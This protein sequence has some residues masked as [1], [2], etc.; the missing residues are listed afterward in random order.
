MPNPPEPRPAGGYWMNETTGVLA[1][2]V[3][4]F[5]RHEPLSPSDIDLLRRSLAQWMGLPFTGP[6]IAD[7]RALI[8]AISTRGDLEHWLDIALDAGIDP[9]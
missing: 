3:R 2:A 4:R 9:F 1:P 8:P 7:L 6:H 5:L